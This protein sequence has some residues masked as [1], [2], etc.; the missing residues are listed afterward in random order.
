MR[1][2]VGDELAA[3]RLARAAAE[4]SEAH[5]SALLAALEAADFELIDSTH[6]LVDGQLL[7]NAAD[8]LAIASKVDQIIVGLLL[9]ERARLGIG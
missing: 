6:R 5:R 8:V 3:R 2:V 1:P 7:V 4:Q 9:D